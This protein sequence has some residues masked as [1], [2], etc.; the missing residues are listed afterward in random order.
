MGLSILS[1][2]LIVWSLYPLILYYNNLCRKNVLINYHSSFYDKHLYSAMRAPEM[3][4]LG[5]LVIISVRR[6]RH[7]A[8]S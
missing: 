8:A 6:N 7:C 1:V 3:C 5:Q 4:G 2:M